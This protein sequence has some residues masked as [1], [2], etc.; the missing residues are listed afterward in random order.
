MMELAKFENATEHRLR[1]YGHQSWSRKV[2]A[3]AELEHDYRGLARGAH[4][5]P[6][7]L[8]E[9]SRSTIRGI[10]WLDG[11]GGGPRLGDRNV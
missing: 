2:R 3:R 9:K 8:P 5:T 11:H 6:G 7:F 10:W 1:E 4:G